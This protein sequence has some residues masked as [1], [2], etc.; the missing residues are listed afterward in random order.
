[1]S[2]SCGC[3]IAAVLRSRRLRRKAGRD[4][5]VR[6]L[7]DG[8]IIS[9]ALHPSIGVNIQGPSAIRVPD[10]VE[11]RLG[12]YY[13]YF[14]DHKGS[15]IRLA[16]ADDP[17]GPWRVHPPGS[18][19]L[20]Q[21]GFLTEPPEVGPERLAAF[22]ARYRARGAPMSH[23][24]LSE[25][26][27]PHIASPDLHVDPTRQRIIMYF[28]GLDDVGTQVTRVATSRDGIAFAAEPQILGPSYMRVF[29]HDGM[30]YAMAMPGIAIAWIMPPCRKIRI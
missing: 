15:Y 9:P 22:E 28:H 21:S 20:E 24:L 13:L 17:A 27:T 26:T 8:P 1:M 6:R 3:D 14:A 11:G 10:W 16:Y 23:D 12:A 7:G 29:A 2:A 19:H 18:L 25:I 4:M 30:V 5:R